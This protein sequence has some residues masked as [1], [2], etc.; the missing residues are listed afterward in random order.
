MNILFKLHKKGKTIVMITHDNKIAL[1][2]PRVI[3]IED[4]KIKYNNLG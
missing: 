1:Q 2:I 4:G 3:E